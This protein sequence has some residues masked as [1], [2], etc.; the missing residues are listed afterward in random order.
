MMG[1]R[2]TRMDAAA[3]QKTYFLA[4]H[5]FHKIIANLFKVNI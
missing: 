4:H 1:D 5:P 3:L 2:R